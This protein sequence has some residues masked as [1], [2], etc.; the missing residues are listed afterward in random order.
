MFVYGIGLSFH[1]KRTLDRYIKL[2]SN[3]YFTSIINP[4]HLDKIDL[5]SRPSLVVCSQ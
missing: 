2:H 4:F 5:Y 1:A 3:L